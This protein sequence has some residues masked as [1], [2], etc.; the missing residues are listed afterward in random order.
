MACRC[1]LPADRYSESSSSNVF[2]SFR[3]AVSK[4]SVNQSQISASMPRACRGGNGV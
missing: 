1:D 3:S 4:L 2:A